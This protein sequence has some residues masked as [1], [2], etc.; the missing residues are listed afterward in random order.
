MGDK[1]HVFKS[2]RGNNQA[3]GQECDHRDAKRRPRGDRALARR[4]AAA[5]R[6]AM[7]AGVCV[8]LVLVAV[9]TLVGNFGFGISAIAL[10]GGLFCV[11]MMGSMGWMM[12]RPLIRRWDNN[13]RPDQGRRG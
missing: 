6:P 4:P 1:L 2:P 7:L 3:L 12:G 9:I 10:L 5:G 11:A 13:R 8:A